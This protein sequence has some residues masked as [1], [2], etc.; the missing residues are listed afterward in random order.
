[1]SYE[2]DH[3]HSKVCHLADIRYSGYEHRF[4]NSMIFYKG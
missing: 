2:L 4:L 3:K 1:M